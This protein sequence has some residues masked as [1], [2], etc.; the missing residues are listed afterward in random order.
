MVQ[1]V[2]DGKVFYV[3]GN[4]SNGVTEAQVTAG[5]GDIVRPKYSARK[6]K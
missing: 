4:Q 3:G 6:K 1:K 5:G 2:V